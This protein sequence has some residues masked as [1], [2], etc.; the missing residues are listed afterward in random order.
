MSYEGNCKFTQ[1]RRLHPFSWAVLSTWPDCKARPSTPLRLIM[2]VFALIL[3]AQKIVIKQNMQ[4]FGWWLWQAL[5]TQETRRFCSNLESVAYQRQRDLKETALG[6]LLCA[7]S[8]VYLSL[9][10]TT[11][12]S[13]AEIQNQLKWNHRLTRYLM[14][15][16]VGDWSSRNSEAAVD[17]S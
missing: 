4:S 6:N 12:Q 10:H 11:S 16:R 1:I 3:E 17:L 9:N 2:T 5:R 8:L 7:L 15:L 13:F 14:I